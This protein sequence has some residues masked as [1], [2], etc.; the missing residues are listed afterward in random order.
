LA[1]RVLRRLAGAALLALM[2]T[3][4]PTVGAADGKAE[5]RP[6]T[7]PPADPALHMHVPVNVPDLKNLE[8]QVKVVVEKVTPATVG[9][10]VGGASG[11]GVIISEDGYVL[12]AGHVS[13]KPGQEVTVIFPD[14]KTV[15]A[16][17]LGMNK[18]I[19]SGLIKITDEGKYPFC[20]MG[21]SAPL[22]K[23]QWVISIGHPGGFKKGRTPPVR[24]GRI[25]ELSDMLVRTDCTLVGG[26]SGGPLFDL[27]GKV[28]GIHSRIGGTISTNIH[29]PVDTYRDT[30]DR[31]AAGDVGGIRGF[32]TPE[33]PYLGL[34][35]GEKTQVDKIDADSPAAKA[36]FK[37]KDVVLKFDGAKVE[38]LDELKAVLGKKKPGDEVSVEVRRGEKEMLTLKIV[39]GKKG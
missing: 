27:D 25:Q 22:K 7:P 31:L 4:L 24:L 2:L 8:K 17:S 23:G 36:G 39:L 11:S 3:V 19:D 18:A 38:T 5:S 28:I 37:E 26:D 15:K 34:T 9:L 33:P 6:V 12:T 16:K 14:G 30:W 20:E 32:S 13:G 29:V 21:K 10:V 1:G 35:F